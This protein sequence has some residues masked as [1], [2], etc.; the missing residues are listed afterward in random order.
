MRRASTQRHHCGCLNTWAIFQGRRLVATRVGR[1]GG[2]SGGRLPPHLKAA[3]SRARTPAI[4]C[5]SARIS[6][7]SRRCSSSSGLGAAA[8]A[9]APDSGV[10]R[11]AAAAAAAPGEVDLDPA[12]PSA[13]TAAGVPP[14]LPLPSGVGDS[15]FF[16]AATA[17]A[18]AAA[19][20]AATA[21]PPAAAACVVMRRALG[22]SCCCLA[23]SHALCRLLCL[24]PQ[25]MLHWQEQ[26]RA[27]VQ[28]R[29]ELLRVRESR[30]NWSCRCML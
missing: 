5:P 11:A 17:P 3:A 9:A 18:A 4:A 12:R 25:K 16:T 2:C 14:R 30:H 20:L 21:P 7:S 29:S 1:G 8:S 19:P 13:V 26:W 23:V 24:S 6:S 27:G 15:S 28:P 10:A 22:Y